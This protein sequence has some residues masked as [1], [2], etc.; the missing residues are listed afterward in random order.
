MEGGSLEGGI[1]VPY[2]G[3]GFST[4][5]GRWDFGFR[6]RTENRNDVWIEKMN[7][8]KESIEMR[9]IYISC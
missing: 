7:Y 6:L 1:V 5:S 8:S 9:C 4:P 3:M 2:S